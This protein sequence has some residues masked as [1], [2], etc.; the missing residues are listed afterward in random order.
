[1][2]AVL[3]LVGC[4]RNPDRRAVCAEVNTQPIYC[5]DVEA[6]YRRE[7]P[8]GRDGISGE[9]ALSLKLSLLNQLIDN[10]LLVQRAV[11]MRIAVA[12]SDVDQAI[13]QLSSPYSAA[14]FQKKLAD[15]GLSAAELRAEV[16]RKLL[17][18]KLLQQEID[19]R[20]ELTPAEV[21]AYYHAHLAQ[22]EVPET[23]Y[24][25]AQILVTPGRSQA[26][27]NLRQDD[28]VGQAAVA[29]KIRQ[30]AKQLRSG[31]DFAHL[32][33]EFSEDP[34]T[35]PGG[36]DMGFVAASALASQPKVL[37]AV[38]A[39]KV[40]QVSGAVR[41]QS[42]NYHILKLLSRENAG[43]RPLSSPEV[44]KTIRAALESEREQ[45]LKTAYL[46]DLRNRAK[47]KDLLASQIVSS[48]G[49]PANLK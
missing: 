47:V 34:A 31:A 3:G 16:R 46:E 8:A 40:G 23:R 33:E 28:A 43:Q 24:H 32:A 5:A 11:Q 44:Q 30:L 14:D 29:R 41:D 2:V 25:L 20:I 15:E 12:E 26:L 9:Q 4:Q 35:A 6:A 27:R 10:Q 45:V 17:V 42:G 48:A 38:N 21:E 18:Q 19:A 36:G 13:A 39:L 37:E 49:N 22:F 7:V 1:M